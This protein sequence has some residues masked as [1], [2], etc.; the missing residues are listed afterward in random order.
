M[1]ANK[2]KRIEETFHAALEIPEAD[3][4]SFL[5]GSCGDDTEIRREVESLLSFKTSSGEFLENPPGS[6]AAEMFTEQDSHKNLI[7]KTIRHYE[8]KELLGK[9]GMGE[10]YLA[11]DTKLHRK[12]AL[13]LLPPQ[14]STD[15]ERKKR[16]EKEALAISALNHP[17]IITIYEIQD[18]GEINFIATEFIEGQTLR[19]RIDNKEL[20]W[21]ESVRIAI[22]VA[23]ALESAHSVGIVHRD[24]K[25]ENIMIRKDGIVKVLDFGLAKLTRPSSGDSIT[26]EQTA[27]HRV[28]GTLNYMSPE[29]A[30]GERIDTRTDVFSF[31]VVLFEMLY[32][33]VPFSNAYGPE[34]NDDKVQNTFSSPG[35]PEK[36]MPA[37]LDHIVK[38]ALKKDRDQR[39]QNFTEFGDDLKRLLS[40]PNTV[41][42]EYAFTGDS[43][44]QTNSNTNLTADS[45]NSFLPKPRNLLPWLVAPLSILV[46]ALGIY[47]VYFSAPQSSNESTNFQSVKLEVLTAHGLTVAAAISPDGKYIV[48]AKDVDGEHS[49]WLR[50][51]ASAGDTKLLTPKET[52]YDH[53]RFSADGD[54]IYFVGSEDEDDT[55]SL[56]KMTTLGRN[57]H[58]IIEDV[59]S[60]VS[61]SPDGKNI[62]FVRSVDGKSSIVTT[63][64]QGKNERILYTRQ[65]PNDYTDEVSWSPDGKLIAVPT[66]VYGAEYSAGIAVVDVATGKEEQIPLKAEKLLRI[67][68]AAWTNDGKGLIFSLLATNM[69]SLYQLRY[70]EYPGG[71]VQ[72]VTNDLTSY[73]DFSLTADNQTL[74]AV[75]REYSMGIWLTPDNDFKSSVGINSKTGADDGALGLCWTKD[76]KIVYVTSEGGAQNIWKMDEDGSNPKPLT[77][78]YKD[79]K[80]YPTLDLGSGLI[81]YL[82]SVPSGFSLFQ[83]DS[84]G[85]NE[86][87]LVKGNDASIVIGSADK[88]WVFYTSQ[89]GGVLHIRKESLIDG[90][91]VQLTNVYS[92]GPAISPDGKQIAFFIR[93]ESKP[94]RIGIMPAEGGDPTKT[95][96]LPTTTYFRAGLVWNKSGDSVLFVNTLGT[97]SNVWSQ[98]LDGAAPTPLTDFKE[99]QIANF[100][101]NAEGN[102]LAIAR[103]SRN[104][105]VVLLKNLISGGV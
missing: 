75:Q 103:G 21:K 39:Y 26:R 22:Q 36:E 92:S 34:T 62:A 60:Q 32:G 61:F 24:I 99:F 48:Y 69:G 80:F 76:G 53:L 101:L 94:L 93:E 89:K 102:R 19:S 95:F 11:E 78:G 43:T 42:P 37:A 88:D 50:Q 33:K 35:D 15:T 100:A 64:E 84:D 45:D 30:M 77:T 67:S 86:R 87:R 6:L 71:A 5:A 79:G 9:G 41:S 14:F 66:I 29:Q 98:R 20:T 7:G 104:R 38:H 46:A 8:I 17:N 96:L 82:K 56:F 2:L 13:K 25:P 51:T 91:E 63:D 1:D 3:L 4:D 10:V 16:F 90:K 18:D 28:M 105:N 31:G 81:T 85:Q 73:E 58:K 49:L 55:D 47:W 59:R 40:E 72:N 74:V 12:I 83:M 27:P 68:K 70:V 44:V 65:A 52:K 97:T 54:F 57:Q 23:G